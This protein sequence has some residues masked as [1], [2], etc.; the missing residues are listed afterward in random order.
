MT[1]NSQHVFI[2]HASADDDFVKELRIKLELHSISVWVDSRNL[3]GGDQLRPEIEEA[4]RTARQF[5]VVISPN[6]INSDWVFDEIEIAEQVQQANTDYR[7][8]P[9]MLPG[10]TPKA[11]KRYFNE[12][13][14][15]EAIEL[16]VGSLQEAMPRILA[17]LGERLPDDLPSEQQVANKPVAELLLELSEPTL[18][19]DEH[20]AEQLSAR[21]ELSYLPADLAVEREVKSRPFRFTAP[22]GQFEQDELRW[23][24]EEYYRWPVGLFRE[25]AERTERQLAQWGTAL[26]AGSLGHTVCQAPLNAWQQV[27]DGVERRFSVQVEATTLADGEDAQTNANEAASRLQSLPWE[28]LYDEAYLSEGANPVRIRRRLPNFKQQSPRV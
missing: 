22:I 1:S 15:G 13:P 20:G 4:I 25:R 3:R 5:L 27:R 23:Y 19:R 18:T 9:L 17:A 12:E 26:F 11:L 2:S 7:A 8:I 10:I 16:D 28:L 24:L 21:A 14:A 6:T